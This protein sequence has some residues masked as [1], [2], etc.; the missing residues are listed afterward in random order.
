[1]SW[2][3]KVFTNFWVVS[4]LVAVLVAVILVLLLPLLVHPL[5]KWIWRLALLGLVILVWGI[6]AAIHVFSAR[7]A[8][9]RIADAMAKEGAAQDEG[10]VVGKRLSD[11]LSQLR[12]QGGKRDYLYSRPW[13]LIIG[14]PGA[15]KTT[16]LESS[17]L[18]FPFSDAVVRGVG[19][20]R[21]LDFMF[22]D[23][24]VLVDTAGRYT[25]QDSQAD[26]DRQGW[27]RFL[28]ALR[29]HRPLQPVNGVMVAIGVDTL[30]GADVA[31]I[32]RHADLIRRRLAELREGLEIDV[33]VYVIFTKTD[34]LAGFSEFF[35]DLDVEQRR[36][37]LGSTFPIERS[38]PD[39]AGVAQ[40]FDEVAEAVAA[41]APKRLQDELDARRRGLIVGFAPQ[42]AELRNAVT[43]L[44]EG[45]FPRDA[46]EGVAR[47]RGFYFTSG[48]QQG[49]PLDKLLSGVASVYD[50]PAQVSS[51]G[52]AY[53][54]NRLLMEVIFGEAGLAEG[55]AGVKARRSA[56][57]TGGLVAISVLFALVLAAWI[58][59]FIANLQFENDVR[60]KATQIA[61]SLRARPDMSLD[62]YSENDAPLEDFQPIFDQLAA[63]PR[64]Y[65][66]RHAKGGVPWP[67]GLGLYQRGLSDAVEETYLTTLK[68]AILPREIARL[69]QFQAAHADVNQATD[70][71]PALK[72]YLSL[73]K[74]GPQGK[75]D[76]DYVRGWIVRDWDA[77]A[78]TAA[79]KEARNA[80]KPHLA[81]MFAARDL[82]AIWPGAHDVPIDQTTIVNSQNALRVAPRAARIY[83]AL[84]SGA[85]DKGPWKIPLDPTSLIAFANG[86]QLQ[87]IRVPF[88]F[89]RAGM[90]GAY[91]PGLKNIPALVT[92]D[93]WV[94]GEKEEQTDYRVILDEVARRY[95]AEYEDQWRRV[96]AAPQPADI[97]GLNETIGNTFISAH[98]YADLYGAVV[99]QVDFSGAPSAAETAAATAQIA[100]IRI[101]RLPTPFSKIL[102]DTTGVDARVEITKAFQPVIDFYKQ[103]KLDDV[104]KRIGDA[105]IAQRSNRQAQPP[106]Q[107]PPPIPPLEGIEIAPPGV[108]DFMKAVKTSGQT[109]TTHASIDAVRNNYMRPGGTHEQCDRVTAAYPFVRSAGD[110]DMASATSL[111]ATGG[112][113]DALK[114]SLAQ[115]IDPNGA[116]HWNAAAPAD[117]NSETPERL[118][119]A[120]AVSQILRGLQMQV[121]V[122][123]MA[124][125]M[126]S[127]TMRIGDSMH[128]FHPNAPDVQPMRWSP[129]GNGIAMVQF[130]GQTASYQASGDW[131]VFHLFQLAKVDRAGAG[132]ITARFGSG[133]AY[134][135]F[136]IE[137]PADL[138][139][140]NPFSSDPW[141]FRCPSPL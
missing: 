89:T 124:P 51:R 49:T 38:A 71:Y 16:A 109:A 11:A 12:K 101:P 133:A 123:E 78:T 117:L 91:L 22:A 86:A 40:A 126:T 66:E 1:M 130:T 65:N 48:I 134:V 47:L 17:G 56:L 84:K 93:Q 103:K 138:G 83:S 108:G 128:E 67:L 32:D 97:F 36:A 50:T 29:K 69:E 74:R 15:G 120:Q 116:W 118:R 23:E 4:I 87:Q 112:P 5:D 53:F 7:N 55:T 122:K 127:A 98:P 42:F 129:T 58:A 33:P 26:R 88:F 132:K 115:Y 13:Y 28:D 64:G 14:P 111:F 104:L 8:S 107:P 102:A 9:D 30:L 59:S 76:G 35:D 24:A 92:E 105:I 34:L 137:L 95:S 44:L 81:I 43:R 61:A 20:T 18:R 52:R 94:V 45:A 85:P 73:G 90:Y 75:V 114:S 70:L 96:L 21:N 3:R 2:L 110:A 135:T 57:L 31:E 136:L 60:A 79:L 62:S 113:L 125:G 72:A 121:Q 68:R 119:Q 41:R 25:S 6:F 63:M 77:T 46:R 141:A 37:V 140:T 82:D 139:N 99:T 39:A 10:A 19:G 100:G 54:L 80:L 131:A 106:G 27:L